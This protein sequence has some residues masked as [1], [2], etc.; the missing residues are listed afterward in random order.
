MQKANSLVEISNW[1]EEMKCGFVENNRSTDISPDDLIK[2]LSQIFGNK[3]IIE[4]A[5][6]E[7][8]PILCKNSIEFKSLW[9]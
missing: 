5:F 3:T 4:Y 2:V 9:N 1:I 8:A 6:M 7:L